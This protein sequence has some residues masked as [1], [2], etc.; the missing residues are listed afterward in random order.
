M[1][2]KLNCVLYLIII[3][4]HSVSCSSRNSNNQVDCVNSENLELNDSLFYLNG[5]PF[6]GCLEEF[7]SRGD[8]FFKAEVRNGILHGSM[9]R[10]FTGGFYQEGTYSNGVLRGEFKTFYSDGQLMKLGFYDEA[11]KLYRETKEFYQDGSIKAIHNYSNGKRNGSFK[12]FWETGELRLE[13]MYKNGV[14]DDTVISYFKNGAIISYTTY[15]DGIDHIQVSYEDE[16][17]SHFHWGYYLEHG[18]ETWYYKMIGEDCFV[19]VYDSEGG[20]VDT[21]VPCDQIP[22]PPKIR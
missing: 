22:E 4:V 2:R 8:L 21:V 13:G 3:L 9:R 14:F 6:S 17:H 12:E 5:S 1:K 10:F 7:S 19:R 16:S 18:N 20:Y 11:G 15:G